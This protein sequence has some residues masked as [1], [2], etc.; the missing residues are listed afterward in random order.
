MTVNTQVLLREA[1]R[2]GQPLSDTQTSYFVRYAR[3]LVEW[4][5][6]IN[7]TAITE[8]DGIARLHFVDSLLLRCA[9]EPIENAKV[10]D[11]GTG[12]GFPGIPLK[13]MRP[14]IELTLLD[15]LNKRILF[16]EEVSKELGQKNICIHSRAE[17]A[18]QNDKYREQYDIATARAVASLNQLA[19]YCL[20]FIKTG[21]YFIALKGPG[22]EEEMKQ[23]E[24]AVKELGGQYE[25]ACP[26]TLADGTQ[27]GLVVV[28]KISQTPTKYPR[29]GGKIKKSPL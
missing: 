10:I 20:P 16:L 2:I 6:K 29:M 15:S 4:N 5:Q 3:L 13:I 7:L 1:E 27:R 21:G 22:Y 26:F 14:D 28:K 12:A 17:E 24:Q 25:K 23:A 18:G 11:V 19:E 9:I 8:P